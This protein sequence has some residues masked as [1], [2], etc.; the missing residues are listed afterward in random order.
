MLCT[1]TRSENATYINGEQQPDIFTLSGELSD[2]MQIAR[3][4]LN[5]DFDLQTGY[6]CTVE[7]FCLDEAEYRYLLS[8]Q[9]IAGNS[10]GG[11][12]IP[13]NPDNNFGGA[14]L[15]HFS[16]KTLRAKRCLCP[17]GIFRMKYCGE[18]PNK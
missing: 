10:P 16:A 9:R 3:P 11:G 8:L 14:C 5:P 4:L 6:V 2:G 1:K 15:G 13:A 17:D 12:S 18:R 7:M